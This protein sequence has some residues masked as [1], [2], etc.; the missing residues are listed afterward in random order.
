M[1]TLQFSQLVN[2][3]RAEALSLSALVIMVLAIVAG[4]GKAYLIA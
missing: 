4:D 3:S 2:S 1:G